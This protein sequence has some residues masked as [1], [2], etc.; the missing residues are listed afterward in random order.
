MEVQK[1]TDAIRKEVKQQAK[2]NANLMAADHPGK[3]DVMRVVG[4]LDI[5]EIAKRLLDE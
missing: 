2:D 5:Y 3:P 4:D 1:L